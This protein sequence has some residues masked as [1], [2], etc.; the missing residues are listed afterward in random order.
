[1][2][3]LLWLC[4]KWH[5]SKK[6]GLRKWFSWWFMIT[7]P[8]FVMRVYFSET[9]T[10]LRSKFT[11]LDNFTHLLY[12]WLKVKNSRGEHI[13]RQSLWTPASKWNQ[14]SF[15]LE[16]NPLIQ[17]TDEATAGLPFL[18]W[19][20]QVCISAGV[21]QQGVSLLFSSGVFVQPFILL[22]ALWYSESTE[23]HCRVFQL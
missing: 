5:K 22:Q 20:L 16:I 12:D 13:S 14:R 2:V 7:I 19:G 17:S 9:V 15:Y 6:K 10:L 8:I 21:L 3:L 1:M 23:V 11:A 4:L 18:V